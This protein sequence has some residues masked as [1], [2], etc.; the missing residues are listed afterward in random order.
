MTDNGCGG[1]GT[2][3]SCGGDEGS[4][5]KFLES[6]A[7]EEALAR[8]GHKIVVLSGKGGVGKST[9]AVNLAVSL[10]LSG[11]RVGLLDVDIHGPSVP[12]LL[13]LEG[14]Q[15]ES[16]NGKLIP[17]GYQSLKVI[18]IG[19]LLDEADDAIIWRGP[20]KAGVIKQFV[21]DVAWGDLDYLVVDCPPGTGDEPL[22]VVQTLGQ[23]DGAV[24][25]T[26][27][28]EL[29]VADVRKSITFC[30]QLKLP[31]IGVVENM[32]GFTCPHCGEVVD[33][34]KTGGGEAMAKSMNVPFLGRIP[35]DPK[36]VNAGDDGTPYVYAYS[37]TP[38]AAS[39]ERVADSVIA[40]CE[41]DANSETETVSMKIAV[42]TSDGQ[43]C[44]H[45]GHC[46]EFTLFD[47]DG[48][49]KS[50]QKAEKVTPPPHEPGLLPRWLG[51]RGVNMV[52]AG[53]MGSRAQGLFAEAG[54][55]VVTGAPAEDP[56]SVVTKYLAGSL[57]T[58][59]NVCDH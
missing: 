27:P 29:A 7:K 30:R 58:G 22:S 36:V 8:I 43:V 53:G 50:I 52:I 14:K 3:T 15:L 5:D 49:S 44:M 9:V 41:T 51:E 21:E 12:K 42:P 26:T 28:Q 38:S 47:V 55:K 34:F 40:A 48:K 45:F 4:L 6:I 13:K 18:S 39:L 24:V 56:E 32:S 20:M 57:E 33:L 35:L 54:V 19:F 2:C 25:V 17:V 59:A 46:E 31:V 37:K 10:A 1:K 16:A 11:K 23:A